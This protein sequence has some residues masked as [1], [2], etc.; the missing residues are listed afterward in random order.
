MHPLKKSICALLASLTVIAGCS[1]SGDNS[2][3][4]LRF[5]IEDQ[6]FELE[7]IIFGLTSLPKEGWQFVEIGQDVTKVNIVT[8]VPSASIQWRMKLKNPAALESRVI[9]LD[10]VNDPA[11]A[12]PIALFT[13]TDDINVFNSVDST[14][15][16][17]D[18]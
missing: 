12:D 8:T 18:H 14:I 1:G 11:M 13:L 6:H 4:Y 9:D 10:D 15:Y 7:H 2:D 17:N 5:H 3:T 16:S